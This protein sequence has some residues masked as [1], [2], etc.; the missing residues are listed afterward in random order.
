MAFEKAKKKTEPAKTKRR[1]RAEEK[2]KEAAGSTKVA[3]ED[4][5]VPMPGKKPRSPASHEK[6]PR[7]APGNRLMDYTG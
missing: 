3:K 7:K 5:N 6:H 1:S 4:V 2:S